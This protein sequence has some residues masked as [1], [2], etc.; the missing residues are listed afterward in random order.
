MTTGMTKMDKY[1]LRQYGYKAWCID[2]YTEVKS[3]KN[4]GTWAWSVK[5]YP[6]NM[7]QGVE[8]MLDLAIS[9]DS[10]DFSAENVE[11]LLNRYESAVSRLCALLEQR[12]ELI[13]DV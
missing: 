6:G 7:K 13:I 11:T 2:Q 10:S 12:S 3:G 4:K 1:R 8:G 5:W 9:D